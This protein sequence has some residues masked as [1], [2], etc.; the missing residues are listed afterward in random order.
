MFVANGVPWALR[1]WL[2][3]QTWMGSSAPSIV[4]CTPLQ[5][6]L[7]VVFMGRSSSQA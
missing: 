4:N 6:Q 5:R 3:W 2:Q 1:H 7:P